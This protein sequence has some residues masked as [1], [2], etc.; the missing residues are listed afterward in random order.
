MDKAPGPKVLIAAQNASSRIGGEAFLPVKFFQL[1]R[2][3]GHPV[4]LVAHARNRAELSETLEPWLD[5]VHFIEDSRWH[6]LVWRLGKPFPDAV[7]KPIFGNLMNQLNEAFQKRL[8]RR[9]IAEGRVDIVHQ[10][11]PVSP[12]APS[13]L[14]GL[15]VPVVIGPMNGD[16]SYPPDYRDYI[17]RAERMFIWAA[18][19]AA[20]VVN[21]LIPGKRRAAMLLV[22]NERTRAALPV[23]HSRV[24]TLV[25]NGVDLSVWQA[26][27]RVPGDTG[28]GRLR[29]VFMGRLIR[30]K[31]MDFTLRAV[32][33]ARETGAD[34]T[35]AV[36]G[37]GAERRGLE[38]LAKELEIDAHVRFHGYRPQSECAEILARSDALV[39]A[40][41]HECGGAVVLEAMGLGLPVIA[42]DW[43][44]PADYLD[45][46]CGILVD[47]QPR[48]D[49][50]DR[51]ADA[52]LRLANDPDLRRRMG[53]AGAVRV[54]SDFDWDRKIDA[55]LRLYDESITHR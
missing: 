29:L 15:C 22:A 11:I 9:L 17:G 10:P 20:P 26:P 5:D 1:L 16:M 38:S 53:A 2:K 40:S 13:S 21:R 51:L 47:P 19:L 25:E 18:R 55:I 3:R 6:R 54:R 4:I 31:G 43:G 27:P 34:V 46:S 49:F 37:D 45:D 8:I 42:A 41:L 39:L 35:L 48:A 14:F 36:L 28:A 23:S 24:R 44:G 33:K 32:A 50:A 7:R 12:R 30:L 52:M